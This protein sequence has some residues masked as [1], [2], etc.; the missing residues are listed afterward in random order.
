MSTIFREFSTRLG[1]VLLVGDDQGLVS[2]AFQAGLQ[3]L[4]PQ[5]GWKLDPSA[6]DREVRSVCD[7]LEGKAPLVEVSL[8]RIEGTEFQRL[9]WKELV[10]IPYGQTLTYGDLAWN[11]R[12]PRASRAVGAACGANPLPLFIPCHRVVGRH[13]D[14]TGFSCGPDFKR[15]LLEIEGVLVPGQETVGEEVLV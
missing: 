5:A 6:F 14:L 10:K 13:G 4:E 9:V 15:E 11:L 7:Y 8:G 2:L 12:K 3:P 1:P